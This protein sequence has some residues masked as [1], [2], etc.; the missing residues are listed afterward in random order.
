MAV[1][2]AYSVVVIFIERSFEIPA[3]E[4]GAEAGAALGI[5]IGILVVFRNNAAYD[6]WWEARKLWGQLINDS[7][8]L[9]LKAQAHVDVPAA[10]HRLLGSYIMSFANALRLHLRG[11]TGV[12]RVPGYEKEP[13]NFPH[14]PG[15]FA[16]LVHR[17]LDQWNREGK[18]RDT[19]W[20]LDV[21]ARALLDVCG[22]CERIRNTPLASSYRALVRLAL[23]LYVMT[24][25]WS[26]SLDMGWSALP[27]L[28]MGFFFLLGIEL[29]A[30]DVE[31]PFG[32]GA[33]EL[34]LE[35]YCRT[36]EEFVTAAVDFESPTARN[37]RSPMSVALL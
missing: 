24:A 29:T 19:M 26:I 27:A 15:Y 6:R 9:L 14:A 13:I 31:M 36:I 8:N 7:R 35:D 17:L 3:W 23:F 32:S 33:D 30:E 10:E 22:A 18:L 16:S 5:V 11:V 34:P 2:V 37:G 28:G 20:V 12:H 25:P 1:V 4:A 21:H